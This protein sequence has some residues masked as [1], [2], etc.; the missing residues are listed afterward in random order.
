MEDDGGAA[1]AEEA[2]D[3][4]AV[5]EPAPDMSKHKSGIIPI[6]QCVAVCAAV[7]APVGSVSPRLLR[8]NLVA[9]VNLDTKLD[10]KTIT[11]HARNAEYNPKARD[12]LPCAHRLPQTPLTLPLPLS[13]AQRFA[14]VIMRIRDPK[15]TALIFASGKMARARRCLCEPCAI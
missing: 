8:R 15:T 9:T 3:A 12:R 14:A 10:L 5:A 11:L 13:R 6:L 7:W 1:G 2:E 4:L